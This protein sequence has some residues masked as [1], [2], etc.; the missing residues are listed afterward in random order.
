MAELPTDVQRRQP[1]IRNM[2]DVQAAI[3]LTAL[4]R[5][6]ESTTRR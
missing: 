3:A 5:A 4:E 1:W 6:S 2:S